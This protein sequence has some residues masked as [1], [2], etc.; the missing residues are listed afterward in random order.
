MSQEIM[1]NPTVTPMKVSDWNQN[2][3]RKSDYIKNRTHYESNISLGE[4]INLWNHDGLAVNPPIPVEK[5]ADLLVFVNGEQI[6]YTLDGRS[7]CSGEE[8]LLVGMPSSGDTIY[9]FD[10]TDAVAVGT[11]IKVCS[12]ELLQLDEKYIPDSIAR[13]RDYIKNRTH[14]LNK[15]LV[16]EHTVMDRYETIILEP[17]LPLEDVNKLVIYFDGKEIEYTTRN[18]GSIYDK[19]G[20]CVLFSSLGAS[21]GDVDAYD[22]TDS[23]PIGTHIEIYLQDLKQLDEVFIPD[24]VARTADVEAKIGDIGT[25]LDELHNYAQSLVGGDA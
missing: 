7:I 21:D 22:I 3:E 14:Y 9:G 1:G 12:Y 6:E 13:V 10:F 16:A 18:Y 5:L 24:S 15:E 4:K 25:M 8:A 19:D 11:H 20:C 2:D 23:V 17:P